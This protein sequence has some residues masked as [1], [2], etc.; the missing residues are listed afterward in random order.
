MCRASRSPERWC[1]Q[2]SSTTSAKHEP[3][4]SYGDK[5]P[6]IFTHHKMTTGKEGRF[7]FERVFPGKGRIG[8]QILLMVNDGATEVTSSQRVSAEFSAG[9]NTTINLGGSGRP[10]VGKLAPPADYTGRV[11]WNFALIHV[12]AD[13]SPPPRP[14]P[15]AEAQGNPERTRAWWESWRWTDA[16]MAWTSAYETSKQLQWESP[17][18]TAS[19]DRDGSFRLD[20]VPAGNYVLSVRFNKNSA[21]RLSGYHFSV[22]PVAAGGAGQRMELGTLTLRGS[23]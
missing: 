10:V 6:N 21:G 7:V 13:I 20:D 17:L 11:L 15:P 16:G 4:H 14:A 3:I 5:V 18:F 1:G 8:R 22:P 12:Q 19:V 2:N 23:R 9:E